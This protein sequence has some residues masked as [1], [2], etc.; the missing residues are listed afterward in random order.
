MSD[1]ALYLDQFLA[2]SAALLDV[3]VL[4]LKPRNTPLDIAEEYLS[5]LLNNVASETVHALFAAFATG[6]ESLGLGEAA[7]QLLSD[8]DL[9]PVARSVMKMWLLSTWYD[10]GKP[11]QPVRVVSS[12]AYKEG[13]VWRFMQSHPIGYSMWKFGYWSENPPDLSEFVPPPA[14]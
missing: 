12:Q 13:L 3:D 14:K 1:T 7:G 8:S 9:G 11:S 10:P 6:S 2:L 4:V 5:T